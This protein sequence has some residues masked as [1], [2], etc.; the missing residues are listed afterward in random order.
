MK[1]C[2]SSGSISRAVICIALFQFEIR[3]VGKGAR[4]RAHRPSTLADEMMDTLSVYAL[5]ASPDKSLCP[6]YGLACS[7]RRHREEQRDETI[8]TVSAERFLDCFASARN[9]AWRKLRIPAMRKLPVV[10]S[11]LALSGKSQRCFRASRCHMRGVSRS[12]RTLEAGCD[13][14]GVSQ[15]E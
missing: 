11:S 12:S 2:A 14:R 6:P 15:D 4:R 13:G 8:Q 3:G 10:Q 1:I 5:R 7:L 9:D